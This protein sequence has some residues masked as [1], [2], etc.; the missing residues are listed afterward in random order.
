MYHMNMFTC[1][2]QYDSYKVIKYLNNLHK[3]EYMA[4]FNNSVQRTAG[5]P[6][7]PTLSVNIW[8]FDLKGN[9]QT[10]NRRIKNN[11]KTTTDHSLQ[12]SCFDDQITTKL[13][14]PN[15]DQRHKYHHLMMTL[16]LTLKMTTAQVVEMSVTNNSLSD[17]PHP[18]DHTKQIIK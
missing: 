3:L 15:Q 8:D 12:L 1:T 17:Y 16:H 2:F 14:R 5:P 18:D 13:T 9:Q 6:E 4:V 10:N 11:S 7:L